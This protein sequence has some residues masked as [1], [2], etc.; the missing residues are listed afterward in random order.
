[1]TCTDFLGSLIC[2][3]PS[4]TA[5]FWSFDWMPYG[6]KCFS[7]EDTFIVG[8]LW[9]QEMELWKSKLGQVYGAI[10]IYKIPSCFFSCDELVYAYMWAC[11]FQ[12][13]P[14]FKGFK[15]LH[16]LHLED[17]CASGNNIGDLVASNPNL[18]KLI[19]SRLLS[20]A[21]INI[22]S[23][24]LEILTIDDL[25]NHLNLHT[26]HLTSAVIK[27]WVETAYASKAGCNCN[28]SQL[29]GSLSD[30]QNITLLGRVFECLAHGFLPRK[31]PNLFNRLTAITLEI[32]VGNLRL[33]FLS[34]YFRMPST[35]D[36]LSY[37]L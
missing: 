32:D 19:L 6:L 3:S 17:F 14:L 30:V 28:L 27:L 25:F 2:F 12:L 16:T 7:L 36:V 9:C 20:F 23:A 35:C 8:R 34:A 22:R 13:P 10:T 24:K 15:R 26:P 11:V 33:K 5:Q 4:T 29:V 18:E 37:R 1:M 31:L 21:D